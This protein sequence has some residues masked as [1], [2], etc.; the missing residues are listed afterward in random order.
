MM[1]CENRMSY[2]N[3]FSISF[4]GNALIVVGVNIELMK[5]ASWDVL[6]DHNKGQNVAADGRI[7]HYNLYT[8]P[9]ERTI[10]SITAFG[11]GEDIRNDLKNDIFDDIEEKLH[12]VIKESADA[13]GYN[14][15]FV[16]VSQSNTRRITRFALTSHT[17]DFVLRYI[18]KYIELFMAHNNIC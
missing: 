13:C 7:M 3:E 4:E 10:H 18:W 5:D 15:E 2:D 12:D 17:A 8:C 9:N 6:H 16:Y 11:T 14:I 1:D